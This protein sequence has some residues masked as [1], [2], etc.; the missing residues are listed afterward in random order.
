MLCASITGKVP[1]FTVSVMYPRENYSQGSLK[2]KIIT[3]LPLDKVSKSFDA[4]PHTLLKHEQLLFHDHCIE[5]GNFQDAINEW[6][7]HGEEK[8]D[9]PDYQSQLNG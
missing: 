3:T 7:I 1:S 2:F 6:E 8:T 9:L 4:I 5:I